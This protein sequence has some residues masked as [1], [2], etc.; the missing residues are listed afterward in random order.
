MMLPFLILMCAVLRFT[1]L[2]SHCS[3]GDRLQFLGTILSL[4]GTMFLGGIT[5]NQN[6][7]F[8][9]RSDEWEKLRDRWEKENTERPFFVI[10][11]VP[12]GAKE[13]R[14][15]GSYKYR[16]PV[17][18]KVFAIPLELTNVGEGPAIGFRSLPDVG[19]GELPECDAEQRCC[20]SK[21]SVRITADV[22]LESC[23]NQG[24]SGLCVIG[25]VEYSNVLGQEYNQTVRVSIDI[26]IA[27][28]S[29]GID[30]PRYVVTLWPLSK[31][32]KDKY[33]GNFV[34]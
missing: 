4:F 13:H 26:E 17:S 30:E 25:A 27:H 24:Q 32:R 28:D 2:Y 5:L 19:F 9:K 8:R 1:G 6:H 31:Q 20:L 18:Q 10:A 34:G 11:G 12:D 7:Q 14:E 33:I 15:T 3:P 29:D 16:V 21:E 23:L 22:P